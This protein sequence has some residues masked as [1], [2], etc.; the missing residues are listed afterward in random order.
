[1]SASVIEQLLARLYTDEDFRRVFLAAPLEMAL[2]A[3]LDSA[4]AQALAAIDRD[5]LA[6]AAHSYAH[7][8]AAHSRKSSGIRAGLLRRLRRLRR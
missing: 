5:G 7:K 2:A 4:E 3:G 8:R 1:M 6:M